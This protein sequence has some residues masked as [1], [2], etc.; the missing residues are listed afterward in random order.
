M[1]VGGCQLKHIPA[2]GPK[3]ASLHRAV[4]HTL[5]LRLLPYDQSS[6]KSALGVFQEPPANTAA[7]PVT[8]TLK[9]DSILV[10]GE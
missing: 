10:K 5:S 7:Y 9:L 1:E 6:I 2:F 4:L 8:S 3:I